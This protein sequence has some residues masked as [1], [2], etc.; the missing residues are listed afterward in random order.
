[1]TIL[2]DARAGMDPSIRPQDD[3]F[4]HVNGTWLREAQI[5]ADRSSWG[6][7]VALADKSEQHVRAIIEELAAS[8]GAPG[9]EAQ[10]IG[11]LYASFMDTDA[12]AERGVRP[13]DGLRGAVDGLRDAHDLAAFLGE[14]ERIGGHGLFGSFVDNDDKDSDRYIFNL[15]QGGLGLPDESYY[16]EEKFAEVREKYTAYLT[17]LYKLAEHPDPEAAAAT[18]LRIDIKIAQGHWKREETRDK[19]KT[20]NLLTLDEL[21]ELCPSFDWDAY[22]KN[23][24]GSRKK[25]AEVLGEVIVRQPSFFAHLSKVLDEVD[26]EEWKLWLY[27]HVLRWSAPYLTEDFV[28]A[29]F[30]FYGRTLNGQPEQRDRWKRGVALVEG[31]LGEAVG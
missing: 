8:G 18:V 19:Q 29:N 26:I 25:V 28:E 15:I 10:K 2:D 23:L 20:Y 17:R 22:I 31:A 1:M 24:S 21:K 12:I 5:P 16:K 14:V 6:A 11:D 13:L 9:S 4:G 27:F 7:F 30:D 3:L